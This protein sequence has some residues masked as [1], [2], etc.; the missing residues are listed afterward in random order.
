MR[1]PDVVLLN[2]AIHTVDPARPRAEAIAI[3]GERIVGV[4]SSDEVRRLAGSATR[5][6]DLGGRFVMP[7]FND[8]HVHLLDGA[9]QLVGIDLRGARS[10]EEF[11]GILAAHARGLPE[12]TW[13]RGGYWDH[14][15][16]PGR[17]MPTRAIID[18]VTPRHPVF[19]QRLDGHVAVANS[20]ALHAAGI[21]GDT[22]SPD[23]GV[24]QRDDLGEPSGVLKDTAMQLVVQAMPP[25]GLHETIA[26]VRAA[27]AHAASLGVTSIHDMTANA[28]ELRAYQQLRDR[29]DLTARIYSIQNREA[30]GLTAAGIATGFGDDW[31]RIGGLKLFADG[32]MGAGT[33]YFYEPYSDEPENSGLLVMPP[34]ELEHRVF[35][36]DAAGFQPVIHAIGDRANAIVLDIVG[37]LCLAR[38]RAGRRVR[39]E[40]AQVV[41]PADRGRFRELGI[42]ASLQPSHC[43]DDMR[44]A[45]RRIGR[46]RCASAYNVRSFVDEGAAVAFGTD[47][48]VEPLDPM[49]GLYA[50]VT[51]QFPDGTPPEG[52][53]PE[54]RLSMAQAIACYTLGS[55]YAEFAEQRKGSLVEGKLG[56][57][58]VL[59]A[60]LM[61][62][63]AREVLQT[64][65]LLTMV[66]GRIVHEL[67]GELQA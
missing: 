28:S 23:G 35:E 1:A 22:R 62:V 31:L 64:R 66:G 48:F 17:N 37:K 67:E 40:H 13:I 43:I 60:N 53:F 33:A 39:V 61:E 38:G 8:A 58:V 26:K 24:I 11:V 7:G 54:Q 51:R 45:E 16:W 41:R 2:G 59:S 47:W 57:L 55:A 56:D 6:I 46:E 25:P 42:I 63:P 5:V 10:I 3:G 49:V 32:S 44:W 19:V 21:T 30:S 4:G 14:E 27:L 20:A 15:A 65:V 18:P 36:A 12:G 34:A 29:G 52:F 9:E 50:A